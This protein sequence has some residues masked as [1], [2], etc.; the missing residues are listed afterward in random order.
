MRFRESFQAFLDYCN[1]TARLL[2]DHR[3][4]ALGERAEKTSDLYAAIPAEVDGA[5]WTPQAIAKARQL[6]NSTGAACT[7]IKMSEHLIELDGSK[8]NYDN[9]DKLG[10]KEAKDIEKLVREGT[11]LIP[12]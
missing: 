4:E 6:H 3:A 9:L 11:A 12:K 2:N 8:E 7:L 10:L 1:G 5:A